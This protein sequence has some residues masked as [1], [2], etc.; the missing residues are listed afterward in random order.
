MPLPRAAGEGNTQPTKPRGLDYPAIMIRV[1][2]KF[3]ISL[4][5]LDEWPIDVILEEADL[6]GY[7]F[8]LDNPPPKAKKSTI[9]GFG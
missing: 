6:L 9:P 3:G 2:E 1:A 5:A 8:D 7:L 4:R